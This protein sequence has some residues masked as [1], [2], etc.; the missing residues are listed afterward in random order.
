MYSSPELFG[1]EEIMLEE[2]QRKYSAVC[3]SAY[4]HIIMIKKKDFEMKVLS[5]E[6][7]FNY[8]N[9]RLAIKSNRFAR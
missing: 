4:G 3:G 9:T 7:A 6:K 1:E 8:L 2:E 5:E